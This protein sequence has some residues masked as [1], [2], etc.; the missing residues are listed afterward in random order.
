MPK[1]RQDLHGVLVVDK[2]GLALDVAPETADYLLTSH[3]VVQRVRRWSGQ[4]R[5]GHTGTL[6][7]LASG[8]LVLCLGAATRLVEYYQGHDKQYT[9]IVELGVA[10]DTY[11]AVGQIVQRCPV[12]ALTEDE[13]EHVLGQFVG[14]IAQKP[15]IFSA[16]K[17]DG[18]SLYRKARRGEKI[19]IAAR[20]VTIHRLALLDYQPPAQIHLSIE[21]SAGTYV[22]SLA[23]DLAQVLGT[24]GHL[25]YLRREAAGGFTTADAHPLAAIEHI[26]T[27]DRLIELL[28]PIGTHLD[29]P[30]IHLDDEALQRLG[31]GQKVWLA[32]PSLADTE[33]TRVGGINRTGEFA[34]ILQVL[35]RGADG[36]ML[37]KAEKWLAQQVGG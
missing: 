28:L 2:P 20:P 30:M 36:M 27:Q 18:E 25:R 6:D 12:P 1:S 24:C 29:L 14:T 17:Q 22:R 16:L 23:H 32:A 9:A 35:A 15:P 8:V 21:C 11:D 7:P 31:H 4:K 13:I 5:I 34:G 26:A 33:E 3:D 10:T 19:E 37:C